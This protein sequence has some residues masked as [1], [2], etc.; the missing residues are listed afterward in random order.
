MV[1]CSEQRT[2]ILVWDMRGEILFGREQQ[3]NTDDRS[4]D[5]DAGHGLLEKSFKIERALC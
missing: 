1:Y 5:Q 4:Q 3:R 2:G